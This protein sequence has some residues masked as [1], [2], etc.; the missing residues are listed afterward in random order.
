MDAEFETIVARITTLL[1]Q[2]QCESGI[3]QRLVYKNKNQHRSSSYFQYL[4]KVNRD[5]KLLQS[6][7]LKE[8]V[9][10]CL[11]VIKGDRPKQ[12]V[13]LL[14]SLKRRKCDNGNYNFME[15][16][17]GAARL[18]AEMVETILKA[19]TEVSILFARSFFMG[20]SVTIMALLARLRV[21]V[22]QILLDVVSLYNMVSSLSKKKQSIKIIS[23]GLEVVREV[24]PVSQDFVKLECVWKSDKFILIETKHDPENENQGEDGN[25]SVDASVVN[26]DTVENFLGDDQVVGNKVVAATEDPSHVTDMNIDPSAGPSQ[27]DNVKDTVCGEEGGDNQGD[28]KASFKNSAKLHSAT[29]KVAFVSIKNHA[30]SSQSVSPLTLNVKQSNETKD[31]AG[32]SLASFF[33]GVNAKDSIF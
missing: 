9:S 2:L 29:K 13:H 33:N 14:E 8:L 10:S 31:D 21:L 28:T 20:F 30:P 3:L 27:I 25:V 5:L 12:K 11:L 17:L 23:N 32:D 26:Y 19:A 16:L 18:L 4:L 7:N 24:F 1:A 15:R 6:A 22:Q